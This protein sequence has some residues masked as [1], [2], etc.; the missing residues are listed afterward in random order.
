MIIVGWMDSTLILVL[1]EPSSSLFSLLSNDSLVSLTIFSLSPSLSP[2]S[3][4]SLIFSGPHNGVSSITPYMGIV[5]VS[6]CD[7]VDQSTL[8]LVYNVSGALL[9][10]VNVPFN[11][12]NIENTRMLF[13]FS[14]SLFYISI[15]YSLLLSNFLSFIPLF[16]FPCFFMFCLMQW[17]RA[18][19]M[20]LITDQITIKH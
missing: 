14:F 16:I 15:T 18:I 19:F 9:Y 2:P 13:L 8:L 20:G 12:E 17:F 1:D 3:S 6:I 7:D 10:S 11:I 4:S 5:V